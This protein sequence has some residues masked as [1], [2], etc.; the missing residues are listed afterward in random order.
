[1]SDSHN[2][3][4]SSSPSVT[5]YHVIRFFAQQLLRYKRYYLVIVCVTIVISRADRS[6]PLLLQQ[7]TDQLIQGTSWTTVQW[8]FVTLVCYRMTSLLGWRITDRLVSKSQSHM[9]AT[10]YDQTRYKI[11]HHSQ[12]F[13]VNTFGGKLTKNMSKLVR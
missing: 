11:Q 3:P 5:N 2:F 4:P 12:Q 10:L 9:L 13:F 7:M 6:I 8:I 1:M